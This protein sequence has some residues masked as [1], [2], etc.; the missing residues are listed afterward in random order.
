MR[1]TT[2]QIRFNSPAFLGNADQNGQWRTNTGS[3]THGGTM[4]FTGSTATAD[5]GYASMFSNR[6]YNYDTTLQSLR[7]PLF[8]T[9]EGSWGVSYWREVTPPS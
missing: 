6:V 2:L 5:G 1:T 7:P 8:P 9:I 4:T 3:N